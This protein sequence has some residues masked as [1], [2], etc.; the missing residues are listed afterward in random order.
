[1][2][3]PATAML[4]AH[5]GT[6]AASEIARLRQAAPAPQVSAPT[7]GDKRPRSSKGG[8]TSTW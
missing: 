7:A 8:R 6:T 4:R 1:M 3:T 2:A 5:S